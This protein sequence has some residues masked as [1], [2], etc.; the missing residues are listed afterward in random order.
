MIAD[1]VPERSRGKLQRCCAGRRKTE[2]DR[3]AD[4]GGRRPTGTELVLSL[5][6]GAAR[7]RVCAQW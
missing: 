7:A 3:W 5:L 6:T 2:Q 4:P 1:G